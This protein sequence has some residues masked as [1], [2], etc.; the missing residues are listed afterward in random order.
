[1][2][3]H[4]AAAPVSVEE[5]LA[6][7]AYEHSEYVNGEVVPLNVG[8]KPHGRIQGRCFRRLDEYLDTIKRGYAGTEVSCRLIINGEVRFRLPDVALVLHDKSADA[9]FVE[10]APDL[11]VEIRSPQDTIASL[12]R[13]M[14][15]YFANGAKLGWVIIPEE[16]SVVVLTN[17][18][19][20]RAFLDGETLD[21]GDVLPGLSIPVSDLFA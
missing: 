6:N 2:G 3:T 5:Y 16:R 20:S 14:T 4:V 21:G 12:F 1:M 17:G 13:K 18:L 19:P 7:P 11:V 9:R 8:S 15:D 10:G